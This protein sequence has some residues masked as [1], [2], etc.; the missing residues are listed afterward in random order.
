MHIELTVWAIISVTTY[1][2]YN[3]LE[4]SESNVSWSWSEIFQVVV[5]SMF[6]CFDLNLNYNCLVG[7]ENTCRDVVLYIQ[8]V[9]GLNVWLVGDGLPE[10]H[11]FQH[12]LKNCM[13]SVSALRYMNFLASRRSK[14]FEHLPEHH[15]IQ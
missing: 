3:F 15:V 7:T 11:L 6:L 8:V 13:L 4:I 12:C 1:F 2:T 9:I 10:I 14:K 5:C